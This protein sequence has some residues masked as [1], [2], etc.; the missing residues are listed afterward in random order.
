MCFVLHREA[1]RLLYGYIR[2]SAVGASHRK[3]PIFPSLCGRSRVCSIAIRRAGTYAV[4]SVLPFGN[5][6]GAKRLPLLYIRR[7]KSAMEALEGGPRGARSGSLAFLFV[8]CADS[9]V[10][11]RRTAAR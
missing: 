5:R 8:A 6:L 2:S 7:V 10:Y 4:A 11:L 9:N 3:A 1:P